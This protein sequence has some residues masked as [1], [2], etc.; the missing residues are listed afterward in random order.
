MVKETEYYYRLGVNPDATADEIREAY[1]KKAQE[2]D[3][4]R[5]PGNPA[6]EVR[7]KL[8]KE[9]YDTLKNKTSRAAYDERGALTLRKCLTWNREEKAVEYVALDD[10]LMKAYEKY[11]HTEEAPPSDFSLVCENEREQL[12]VYT[13]LSALP[14]GDPEEE[15]QFGLFRVNACEAPQLVRNWVNSWYRVPSDF[16]RRTVVPLHFARVLVPYACFNVTM[17][18]NITGTDTYTP[19]RDDPE[20]GG[21]QTTARADSVSKD[22]VCTVC[23]AASEEDRAFYETWKNEWSSRYGGHMNPVT[24]FGLLTPPDQWNAVELERMRD[25]KRAEEER[26]G[27]TLL[28]RGVTALGSLFDS[29]EAPPS[30]AFVM[31]AQRCEDFWDEVRESC[32]D[33][34]AKEC[35]EQWK[36]L[37]QVNHRREVTA[38]QV[39]SIEHTVSLVY[40]PVYSGAYTYAEQKFRV[41]VNGHNGKVTGDAP[42]GTIVDFFRNLFWWLGFA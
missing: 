31:P 39:Q 24:D 11:I 34:L 19:P 14:A 16:A 22:T 6:A 28:G 3:P 33:A 13:M 18:M 29:R 1:K 27:H 12:R 2:L 15:L 40:M 25:K 42:R 38:S 32:K 17:T 10:K 36:K 5:H 35:I 30:D 7:L 37:A 20:G 4:K 9:A 41:A 23:A 8:V 21:P 26:N